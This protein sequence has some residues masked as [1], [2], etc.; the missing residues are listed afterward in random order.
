M[1]VSVTAATGGPIA[2]ELILAGLLAEE[3][4]QQ[5]E[6]RFQP[7]RAVEGRLL[8]VEALLRWCH[9][10][11]G[12]VPPEQFIQVA[13]QHMLMRRLTLWVIS[14]SFRC[15]QTWQLAELDM[16]LSL[17]ISAHDLQSDYLV[18]ALQAATQSYLIAPARVTL[19]VT[20]TLPIHCYQR[21]AARVN[22]LHKL[23]FKV[24]LDDFGAGYANMQ[25]LASLP[26]NRIKLDKSLVQSSAASLKHR[27]LVRSL[28]QMAH[29]IGIDVV[30]EGVETRSEC[31][32]LEACG[33]DY[34]Q[35]YF[36]ATPLQ[37]AEV[38]RW[39]VEQVEQESVAEIDPL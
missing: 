3:L 19:E 7:L 5:L 14:N 26:V 23:G 2:C 8:S 15:L 11:L 28:V 18:N 10:A 16:H 17:N 35:G 31:G 22:Q 32:V 6:L 39:Y 33:A 20:E 12:W 21:A 36:I 38:Q 24:A 30:A 1:T 4:E 34:L 25:Q 29:Q 13:E 37:V 9:P 27:H